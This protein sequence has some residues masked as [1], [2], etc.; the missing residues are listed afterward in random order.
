VEREWWK[1]QSAFYFDGAA[2]HI[3]KEKRRQGEVMFFGWHKEYD[4]VA[5][6]G[7]VSL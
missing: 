2:G 6:A 1:K 3:I 4:R 5:Y 7:K